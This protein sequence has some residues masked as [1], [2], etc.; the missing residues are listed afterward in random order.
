MGRIPG[1]KTQSGAS[2]P[3]IHNNLGRIRLA[4]GEFEEAA[5]EF[6]K[7][8]ELNPQH[9]Q[10]SLVFNNLGDIHLKR[11]ERERAIERFR[12]AVEA[13]P[14][15][16]EARYNLAAVFLA[17]RRTAEAIVLLEQA[18]AL[19][20]NHELVGIQLGMAYLDVGRNDDAYRSF[21]LVRRLYPQSWVAP[22]GLAVLQAASGRPEEARPLRDD[23]LRLGGEAARVEAANWAPLKPLLSA[24]S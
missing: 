15:Q 10:V 11:G 23:A 16:F 8:L 1:E 3:E 24:G 22:L 4:R 6:S 20:P 19:Q 17:E 5:R 7:A 9:A 13:S 12:Q 18:S 2:S 21:L 14:A